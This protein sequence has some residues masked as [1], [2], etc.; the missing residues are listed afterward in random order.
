MHLAAAAPQASAE[1]ADG[2]DPAPEMPAASSQPEEAEPLAA[3]N[4]NLI[5][6][7]Q[8]GP[9]RELSLQ[10]QPRELPLA[11]GSLQPIDAQQP[12]QPQQLN[13]GQALAAQL[14]PGQHTQEQTMAQLS[15]VQERQE[16]ALAGLLK[17]IIRSTEGTRASG[18]PETPNVPP[19]PGR[20]N[21]A[22]RGSIAQIHL[23][24]QQETDKGTR[25]S[26]AQIHPSRQQGTAQELTPQPAQA[27][28]SSGRERDYTLS[29]AP[30]SSISELRLQ[31]AGKTAQT[32]IP[33]QQSSLPAGTRQQPQ[34]AVGAAGSAQAAPE[35]ITSSPQG[36]LITVYQSSD[37]EEIAA[38]I[39]ASG[40]AG[41]REQSGIR[42]DA[43]SNYIHSTLPS[44]SVKAMLNQG[45]EQ[46]ASG[47]G[48]QQQNP[49]ALLQQENLNISEQPA[50][51][52]LAASSFSLNPAGSSLGP[53]AAAPVPP[54]TPLLQLPSGI[55]VPEAAVMDQV[56][57]HFS[58]TTKLESGSIHLRLHPQ[59]LGE[60]RLEIEVKQDNIKAH[61]T[62]QNPQAQEALDRHLPRLRDALEQ[63]GL[64]L[65]EVEISVAPSDQYDGQRFQENEAR[66]QLAQAFRTDT[67]TSVPSETDGAETE[68]APAAEQRL[69]L[70]V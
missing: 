19:G 54:G 45:Q 27:T 50:K 6:P 1:A 51:D 17:E 39:A 69:S 56:I 37:N 52:N 30:G 26:L 16:Q 32:P 18:S 65:S 22:D 34:A 11:G 12:Q 31:P 13:A 46:A 24:G 59:E 61:I 55:T 25:A 43:N 63:Q 68:P 8:L 14:S 60:L 21:G 57:N 66:H 7:F 53:T 20:D 41:T 4:Q 2:H 40:Q 49:E 47:E 44:N 36:Q 5:L 10:I 33:E 28:G 35:K 70:R 42:Q 23:N 29:T 64:H 48:N 58:A 9:D 67:Q 15:P 3:E 62:T 38:K